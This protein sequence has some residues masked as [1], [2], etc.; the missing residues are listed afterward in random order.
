MTATILVL[1]ANPRDT[2]RLRLDQEVREI[3][4]GLQRSRKRDDF[5]LKQLWATRPTDV[6]R[7]VLDLK[8]SIIHFCG[9]G[10]GEDG[11]AFEDNCSDLQL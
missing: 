1:A 6:R 11:I 5:L 4:N 10:T 3:E 2:S 9:H 7:A 8:P